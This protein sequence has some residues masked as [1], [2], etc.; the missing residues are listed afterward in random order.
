MT[1]K[2]INLYKVLKVN[3]PIWFVSGFDVTVESDSTTLAGAETGFSSVTVVMGSL[4]SSR[5][6][7]TKV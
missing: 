4:C 6:S 3:K 2:L 7:S 1:K 5:P